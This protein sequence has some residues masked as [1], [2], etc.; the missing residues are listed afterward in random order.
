[1]E[2]TKPVTKTALT[3]CS[4]CAKNI[5]SREGVCGCAF[6]CLGNDYCNEILNL[7]SQLY[8]FYKEHFLPTEGE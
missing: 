6:R 4:L 5:S 1:M 7:D 8:D 2:K 3:I